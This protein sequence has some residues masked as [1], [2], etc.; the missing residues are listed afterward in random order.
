MSVFTE[1]Q[2]S[3]YMKGEVNSSHSEISRQ[4]E[5]ISVCIKFS[6]RFEINIY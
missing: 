4:R 2:I 1:I 5:I 3:V 6:K